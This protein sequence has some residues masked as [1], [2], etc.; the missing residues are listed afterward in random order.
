[1][2]LAIDIGNTNIVMGTIN[3]KTGKILFTARTSTDRIYTADQYGIQFKNIM[4]LYDISSE[5][6][7]GCIIS[8]VVPPVVNA[9]SGGVERLTGI[10]PIIV[11]PG[12]KTGLNI[13]TD[14]PVQVGSDLVVNAVSALEKFKPP[15]IVIDMGTATTISVV[16]S[17]RNYIGGCIMPGVKVSLD[18]ISR[19][20]A[21][22]PGISLSAPKKTVGK[23]T[24]EC[25]RSGAVYGNAAM[26]DGMVERIEWEMGENL[27]VIATGGIA[28]VII[29]Y[30]RKKIIYDE[31]LLLRGLYII[32]KKNAQPE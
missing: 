28:G 29:P 5:K 27:T 9:V 3:K 11:G 24:V 26:L 31:N 25:M 8:S 13:L 30:C 19:N 7:N 17:K 10:N 16:D 21:Q 18:A 2:I 20:A 14:N 6:I 22:L 1:M 4:E 15:L 23:N 32:Y 12:V